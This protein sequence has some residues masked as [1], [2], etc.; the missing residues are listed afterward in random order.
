MDVLPIWL[1]AGCQLVGWLAFEGIN[2]TPHPFWGVRDALEI[3]LGF[4]WTNIC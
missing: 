1:L 4:W 2:E 3:E